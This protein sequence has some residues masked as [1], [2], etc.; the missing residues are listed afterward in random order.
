MCCGKRASGC[1][2]TSPLDGTRRPAAKQR[3]EPAAMRD[4]LWT[5]LILRHADLRKIGYYSHGDAFED[6]TP[7]LQ[8]RMVKG[9]VEEEVDEEASDEDAGEEPAEASP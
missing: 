1:S 4:R 9:A 2:T 7:K 8:S 3:D 6:V 5:P